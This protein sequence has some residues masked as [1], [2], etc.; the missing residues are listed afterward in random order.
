MKKFTDGTHPLIW[1]Y[2]SQGNI[3][4]LIT[5]YIKIFKKN[6]LQNKWITLLS[7]I[8]LLWQFFKI[9]AAM[10]NTLIITKRMKVMEQSYVKKKNLFNI[11]RHFK[12]WTCICAEVFVTCKCLPLLKQ[13]HV[14]LMNTYLLFYGSCEFLT[15]FFLLNKST[16]ILHRKK[17]RTYKL[18]MWA[19]IFLVIFF[20]CH[21]K[22]GKK[23]KQYL[24]ST[25]C[26]VFYFVCSV[27]LFKFSLLSILYFSNIYDKEC[28]NITPSFSKHVIFVIS[29]VKGIWL[30]TL[31]LMT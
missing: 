29:A 30:H 9:T 14:K 1:F 28:C 17:I 8:L 2:F 22:H 5:M 10:S 25:P 12:A 20:Q 24:I 18:S 26:N 3:V 4:T 21:V 27:V 16:T 13:H 23:M 7:V 31:C 11:L 15:I 6:G 19:T